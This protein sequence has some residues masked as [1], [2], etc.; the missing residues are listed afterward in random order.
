VHKLPAGTEYAQHQRVRPTE[1]GGSFSF[2]VNVLTPKGRW[3]WTS[4]IVQALRRP[5]L[6]SCTSDDAG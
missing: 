3:R 6:N 4:G 2:A 1:D 5:A